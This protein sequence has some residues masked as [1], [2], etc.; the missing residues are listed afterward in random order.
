M[1]LFTILLLTVA[2][3]AGAEDGVEI[4]FVNGTYT[5]LDSD[6]EPIRQGVLTIELTSPRHELVVH[7]NRLQLT[8]LGDGRHTIAVEVE[9]EGTGELTA[10]VTGAGVSTRFEDQ[11][12]ARRQTVHATAV[13]RLE[14][15]EEGYL[16]TLEEPGPP[17]RLEVESGVA[18]QIVQLCRPLELLPFFNLRCDGLERALEVVSVPQPEAGAR[19]LIPSQRLSVGERGYLAGVVGGGD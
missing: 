1:K 7:R 17:V 3:A 12:T 19:F 8:P 4:G 16:M 13:V 14:A 11:I 9:F 18:R 10:A 15:V 5:D 2:L 6:L